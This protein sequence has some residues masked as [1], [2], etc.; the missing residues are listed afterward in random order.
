MYGNDGADH[1][2]VPIGEFLEE[3]ADMPVPGPG[4]RANIERID[5]FGDGAFATLVEADYQGVDYVNLFS[6]VKVDDRWGIVN[7]VFVVTGGSPSPE[8]R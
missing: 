4:Y 3:V 6:L 7:K 2:D 1:Y 8:T 5:I